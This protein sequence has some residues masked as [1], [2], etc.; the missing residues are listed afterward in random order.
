MG[1]WNVCTVHTTRRS[2]SFSIEIHSTHT[3][4]NATVGGIRDAR[5]AGIRPANAPIR[6]AEA[7]PP[8]HASTGITTAQ[9]FELAYTAVAAAPARTPTTP[10]MTASR[11]DSARNCVRIWPFVAPRS[12]LHPRIVRRVGVPGR[13]TVSDGFGAQFVVPGFVAVDLAQPMRGAVFG[14]PRGG[15]KGTDVGRG[16]RHVSRC[17]RGGDPTRGFLF[18]SVLGNRLA[19]QLI[20]VLGGAPATIEEELDPVVGGIGCSLAQ[21]AEQIRVEVGYTRKLVIEDRR[22]VGQGTV[23][24]A[25]RTLVLVGKTRGLPANDVDR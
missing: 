15:S 16:S 5:T 18:G 1:C 2:A 9:L 3:V 11:I 10:P 13:A 25:K 24:L 19:K 14:Q 7:M 22:A 8:D 23:G 6:M 20:L 21:G 12:L 4:R 17:L